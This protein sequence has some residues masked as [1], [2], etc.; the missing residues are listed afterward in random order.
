MPR[1]L[2][3]PASQIR[4]S[5][6]WPELTP[7]EHV[8]IFARIKGMCSAD[9]L[10]ETARRLDAVRLADTADAAVHTLSGG[11]KRRLCVALAAVGSPRIVVL[12]EPSTGLDPVNR[13]SLWKML[14]EFKQDKVIVLTTH[15]M[16][17]AEV[18]GDRIGIMVKG[19]LR[20]IGTP[21]HLKNKYGNGYHLGVVMGNADGGGGSTSAGT[22]LD[23][24]GRCVP[25]VVLA[26]H[27]GRS[28][29]LN[30]SPA[31]L[32][33]MPRLI[34]LLQEN[35]SLGRVQEWGV[36]QSSLEDA[37]LSVNK[38]FNEDVT[39]EEAVAV[40]ISE[41]EAK[42]AAQGRCSSLLHYGA[43]V[44]ALFLKNMTVQW[45][46]KG[47]N[48]CQIA[49]PII[50]L[51][52][53]LVLQLVIKAELG[54][55]ATSMIYVKTA[56]FP[57]NAD[58]SHIPSWRSFS[59]ADFVALESAS[60]PGS[61]YTIAGFDESSAG[62]CLEFFLFEDVNTVSAGN[63]TQDGVKAG[64]LGRIR[65]HDCVLYNGTQ[66]R[67]PFYSHRANANQ[68]D[69]EIISDFEVY[70]E[71]GM[72]Q[73]DSAPLMYLTPDGSVKF[74][75]ID[76][77][78]GTIKFTFA[79]ND[80]T[81][82]PYHRA[83]N[84]TRLDLY[85]YTAVD[86]EVNINLMNI[87]AQGRMALLSMVTDAFGGAVLNVSSSRLSDALPRPLRSIKWAQGLPYYKFA[88]ALAVI[89]VAGTLLY[90]LALS[91]QLPIYIYILVMEKENQ[92]RLLMQA[93]GLSTALYFFVTYIFF[94]LMYSVIVAFFWVTGAILGIR[95][96][97]ETAPFTLVVL[98]V[99]WGNA[100]IA[101]AFLVSSFLNS[102]RAATVV[103]YILALMGTLF[104]LMICIDV[105]G[106]F[107]WSV[108]QTMAPGLL[109]ISQFAM[110]RAIYL[111]NYVC[112]INY[113]CYGTLW[114]ISGQDELTTVLAFLYL[115]TVL[116]LLV[117]LYV[118][119]VAPWSTGV[120]KSPLL[121][122]RRPCERLWDA[123][124][125][126][127]FACRAKSGSYQ[128]LSAAAAPDAAD[129]VVG[130]RAPDG[131]HDVAEEADRV[132]S[133]SY[134][135]S[136]LSLDNLQK[137][138]APRRFRGPPHRAVRGVSF[139][140]EADDCFALLGENG[141]G[142]T[143]IISMLIGMLEPSGGTA[144][145]G[146]FDIRTQMDKVHTVI[147]VCPQFSTLWEELTARQTL[148]FFARLKGIPFSREKRHVDQCLHQFGL[149]D[150]ANRR[151]N[152]LSG[153][154]QRRLSVA[155]ALIGGSKI[156]FLDEPT[157]GL[158]P[159]S[160]RQLWTIITAARAGRAV[161]L[162][163]HAMEEAES[164][165]NK[166]GI[167]AHGTL[168]CVGSS[169]H[170]KNKFE[171][172]Y[173]LTVNFDESAPGAVAEVERLVHQLVPSAEQV[174]AMKGVR[175]YRLM[176]RPEELPAV[177]ASLSQ[178]SA[179]R[180]AVDCCCNVSI[181]AADEASTS[182]TAAASTCISDWSI[183]QIGLEDVFQRIVQESVEAD[184]EVA[185]PASV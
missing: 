41:E 28:L 46:Q 52:L 35:A 107:D 102:K 171:H 125:R 175:L 142:K 70:N 29:T 14:Q 168:R 161:I 145:V 71:H 147:G 116:Y 54:S 158:D 19:K 130:P 21:L 22:L 109:L 103:G 140:V 97:S 144:T 91:L 67:V 150:A 63:L 135:D 167:M 160:R 5:I 13:Q 23:D 128:L 2:S 53:M 156:V 149:F 48:I 75:R 40:G 38:K 6:I 31:Q 163:T 96:F 131:D 182:A 133:G 134:R 45:R 94:F 162:T 26:G 51:V 180:N 118:D 49:T 151:A 100:L 73:V 154:M 69:K 137:T 39:D 16:E 181:N 101:T 98:F 66:V 184:A 43:I 59:F 3:L 105:Y 90:P 178:Y 79:V 85:N 11:M 44:R 80:H 33:Q 32:P 174:S 104:G 78:G 127:L 20:C 4:N 88:D 87:I 143:T 42:A 132:S 112:A 120:R 25:D 30:L 179:S 111:M 74:D 110:I 173:R 123:L 165:S 65:Q 17:E 170:L 155:I 176:C 15:S 129:I 68:L 9:A 146:G 34:G 148:L 152:Q 10:A 77:A 72:D 177:F 82:L 172:G 119:S 138:F 18:L 92:L 95:L 117:A 8:Y 47:T 84:F 27:E 166:I 164:L 106:F 24:I 121:C 99:G 153:G 61:E 113:Q 157:T 57:L 50:V 81:I 139:G 108:A 126:R 141:A 60:E 37:F 58:L 64:L 136:C 124:R 76:L 1:F 55:S 115:D 56:P 169:L 159:A 183:A 114:K 122:L 93:H 185:A 86:L 83:N 7:A 12:D 89:E 62:E 36:S